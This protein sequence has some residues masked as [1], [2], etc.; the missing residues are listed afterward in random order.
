MKFYQKIGLLGGTFDPV[1]LGHLHLANTIQHAL[2]F[3]QV[4]LIPAYSPVHR[5]N[6][7][8][9]AEHRWNMVRIACKNQLALKANDIEIQRK[10]PSFMIDTLSA[11]KE[12]YRHQAL[13]LILGD[14][15]FSHTQ[16]WREWPKCL[17]LANVVVASRNIE[18]PEYPFPIANTTQLAQSQA[19]L[20]CYY[21]WK[22]LPISASKVRDACLTNENIST[23][24]PES[25]ADY[26]HTH[27]LYEQEEKRHET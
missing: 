6:P 5:G 21:A 9:S 2:G 14:E 26:I 17:Q 10:G 8:A 22:A 25:V 18:N 24:V 16:E 1:H 20:I 19:G 11:L 7:R 13:C 23:L 3:M 4:H 12:Q 27:H 15:A